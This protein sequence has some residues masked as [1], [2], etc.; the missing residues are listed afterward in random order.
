MKI[1]RNLTAVATVAA[2]LTIAVQARA[3]TY[4]TFY[5]TQGESTSG[6]AG[7]A[8]TPISDS[9]AVEV[10]IDLISSTSATVT[11]TPPSGGKIETPVYINVND[12]GTVGN[13]HV[14]DNVPGTVFR[15]D[16]GQAEDHFGNMN[17]G[18]PG[19]FSICASGCTETSLIFTLTAENGFT[20]SNVDAV[21]MQTTGYGAAYSQGF[22][23]VDE[24]QY[25][26]F[27]TTTPLPATLMLFGSGLGVMGLLGRRRKRKDATALVAA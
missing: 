6:N 3:D 23:A 15:S 16:P 25:A 11:L 22:D 27:Y 13:V 7:T 18:A 1:I 14:T 26:G 19:G 12:G 24:E 17:A 4:Q 21:L 5:L 10:V 9:S 2:A 20:W 8:P